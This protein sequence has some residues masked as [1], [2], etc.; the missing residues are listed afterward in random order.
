MSCVVANGS[1]GILAGG[2][3]GRLV[4]WNPDGAVAGGKN[5][6]H[7]VRGV[8]APPGGGLTCLSIAPGGGAVV[9][10]WGDGSVGVYVDG[11]HDDAGGGGGG[12]RG[13][14]SSA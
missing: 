8:A 5:K 10:G 6:P 2:K 4:A 13:V 3:D 1:R 12:G 14:S 9:V 11:K 7:V